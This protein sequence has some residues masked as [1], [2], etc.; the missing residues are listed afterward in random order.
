MASFSWPAILRSARSRSEARSRLDWRLSTST[1]V[2]M[3]ILLTWFSDSLLNSFWSM[4]SI[5]R[6]WAADV[7]QQ[8]VRVAQQVV[9]VGHNLVLHELGAGALVEHADVSHQLGAAGGNAARGHL[10]LV[11]LLLLVDDHAHALEPQRVLVND[12]VDGNLQ[13]VHN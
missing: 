11:K 8:R 7:R 6:L 13:V 5:C 4:S 12:R 2:S 10:E 3:I 1:C 9:G